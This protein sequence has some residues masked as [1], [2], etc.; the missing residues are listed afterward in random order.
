MS[1][2]TSTRQPDMVIHMK[3]AHTPLFARPKGMPKKESWS[4]YL[5]KGL[6]PRE[7][8]SRQRANRGEVQH[9]FDFRAAKRFKDADPHHSACIE[10]K[11]ESTVGL[12]FENEKVDETLD[13]LCATTWQD[14][15]TSAVEDYWHT[16]NGWIEVVREGSEI[17]G[18]YHVAAECV[19]FKI[20]KNDTLDFHYI[21]RQESGPDLICAAFGDA[22]RVKREVL[23][24]ARSRQTEVSELIHLR[25]PTS[26]HRWYGMPDWLSAVAQIELAHAITQ[27]NFDFFMNSGVP[28]FILTLIGGGV[29]EED[30]KEIKDAVQS[31]TGMGNHHKTLAI[32]INKPEVEVQVHKLGE[33]MAEGWFQSMLDTIANRIVSAHRVPPLLAGIQI[34]GKLGANNEFINAMWMFQSLVIAP[35]QTAIQKTLGQTLGSGD[36]VKGLDGNGAFKLKTIV[37]EVPVAQIE[38]PGSMQEAPKE[39]GS[40]RDINSQ[41]PTN[42]AVQKSDEELETYFAEKTSLEDRVAKIAETLPEDRRETIIRD[43]MEGTVDR[44]FKALLAA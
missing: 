10:A 14:V 33:Q 24:K 15:S 11:R 17:K 40:R 2:D 36:G 8:R 32:K 18:L 9:P 42:R 5:L 21:V 22:D 19:K 12:G 3:R 26:L 34:P 16:G 1:H 44:M 25:R 29:S 38:A 13:P 41:R 28:E 23:P 35:A 43:F 4:S 20:E 30:W 27:Y 6:L 7:A 39:P 37:E 31:G